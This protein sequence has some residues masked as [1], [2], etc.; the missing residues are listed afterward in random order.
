VT[1]AADFWDKIAERY[2]A[3]P[4]GNPEAFDRKIDV[5]TSCMSPDALVLDIGCGTGSLALRLAPF[6]AHVHGLDIS[7][8]MVR[9]AEDKARAQAVDNV[10]FHAGPFDES[11]TALD[12]ESLDGV[13]A[14]SILHLLDDRA[15]ALARVFRLL[16]P[17]G[18]FISSTPCLG[19]SWVPFGPVLWLM[20]KLG[21]APSVQLFDKRR[22]LDDLAGAGFVDI[23]EPDVG[24]DTA[25][26][27]AKKARS[28]PG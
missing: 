22:L 8:E 21:K 4:V 27:V 15:A 9:I 11:F 12:D 16:K 26:L 2:A 18:F 6:A 24:G 7:R 1:E 25:F 13:C 3:Q 5:T 23:E 17:G 19:G 28:A 14:Y 20:Q 10:S